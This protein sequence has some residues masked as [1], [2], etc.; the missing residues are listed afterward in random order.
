MK[1]SDYPSFMQPG[2]A[3]GGVVSQAKME[4]QKREHE[5]YTPFHVKRGVMD[6]KFEGYAGG[7]AISGP[8][9]PTSDSV[10]ATIDG[11]KPARLSNGEYVLPV[12]AVKH[13]GGGDHTKG[14]QILDKFLANVRASKGGIGSIPR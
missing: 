6:H 4:G 10:P 3:L 12:E 14:T 7:G 1:I 8:G 5:R 11:D 9:G 13:I 2:Y